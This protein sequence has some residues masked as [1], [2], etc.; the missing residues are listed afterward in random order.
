MTGQTKVQIGMSIMNFRKRTLDNVAKLYEYSQQNPTLSIVIF[1]KSG[2]AIDGYANT[3]NFRLI[4]IQIESLY[5]TMLRLEEFEWAHCWWV[6]DDDYFEIRDFG[7]LNNLKEGQLYLPH[8]EIVSDFETKVVDWDK[9]VKQQ[10]SVDSYLAYWDLG[11]PLIFTIIP[12]S[13]FLDWSRFVI[14]DP[15]HLPHLDTHLNVLTSLIPKKTVVGEVRYAYGTENWQD[16]ESIAQ[17]AMKWAVWQSMDTSYIF[18]M[19]L[20]RNIE[21]IALINSSYTGNDLERIL[22]RLLRQ[23]S[24]FQNGKRAW[25]FRNLIPERV[26]YRIIVRENDLSFKQF[27]DK[28]PMPVRRFLTGATNISSTRKLGKILS[29]P[30]FF[31]SLL[32]PS[33]KYSFWQSTIN[34]ES[35]QY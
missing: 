10:D 7:F 3:P 6:N 15:F 4:D 16:P 21:N 34:S 18:T 11:A 13:V 12:R 29:K 30:I 24:P 1:N 20:V 14:L 8:M 35:H 2:K 26:R 25:L 27:C 31:N 9:F 19:N 33:E 28:Y 5:S 32:V 22:R 17:S 23:F